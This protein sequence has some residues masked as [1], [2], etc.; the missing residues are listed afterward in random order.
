MIRSLSLAAALAL[1]GSPAP[2]PRVPASPPA[3]PGLT[4]VGDS[5][6]ASWQ[7]RDLRAFL[8]PAGAGRLVVT[9]PAAGQSAPITAEQARAMLSSYVQGT[10]EVETVLQRAEV[11]DSA[12]GYVGLSR[13]YREVGIPG[14]RQSVILLGYRRGRSAWV[15]T[16]VRIAS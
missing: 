3:L 14:E 7:R 11:V 8:A 2:R 13:R 6:R 4:E 12:Q 1:L 9:L 16:E 10:Q 5:A 15:L